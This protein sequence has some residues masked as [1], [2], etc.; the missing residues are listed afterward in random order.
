MIDIVESENP[1]VA[2]LHS[3]LNGVASS[4]LTPALATS[5]ERAL[6]VLKEEISFQQSMRQVRTGYTPFPEMIYSPPGIVG[7]V[8]NYIL[9]G[10]PK[11]QPEAALAAALTAVGTVIGRKVATPSDL[12]SNIYFLT[13]IESGG[14]KEWPRRAIQKIFQEIGAFNRCRAEDVASDS[15]IYESMAVTQSQALLLDEFGKFLAATNTSSH[16]GQVPA[17]LLRLHSSANSTFAGKL[18]ADHKRNR[19]IEQPNISLLA[20]STRESFFSA[21]SGAQVSD[22]F[23][24]RIIFLESQHPDPP[25]NDD[26]DRT[27][28]SS[29][30]KWFSKWEAQ[31]IAKGNME[32]IPTPIVVPFSPEATALFKEAELLLSGVRQTLRPMGTAALYTRVTDSARRVA[33]CLAVGCNSRSVEADHALYALTLVKIATDNLHVAVRAH[34]SDNQMEAH[35]KKV[36]E[37]IRDAKNISASALYTKT[38]FL[39]GPQRRDI[40]QT[41][42]DCGCIESLLTNRRNIYKYL[43]EG[44]R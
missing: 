10:A 14:G 41:L 8:Y 9:R 28:P 5:H 11:P 34:V 36:L 44:E 4:E 30:I 23:L 19:T 37:I 40:L 15:A 20:T 18:Y 1:G 32:T 39:S 22:G 16:L 35:H 3:V 12:R 21:I 29:V 43:S 26:C 7:E 2:T 25:I 17:L 42:Q 13:L 27:I 24:N 6:S 31:P 33:L 38:R